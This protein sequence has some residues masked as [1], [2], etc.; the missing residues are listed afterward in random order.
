MFFL[1]QI[2]VFGLILIGLF[3]VT[4]VAGKYSLHYLFS[5]TLATLFFIIINTNNFGDRPF[6]F[7]ILFGLVC[8]ASIIKL[9]RK[10]G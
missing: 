8:L 1:T 9:M 7:V 4:K 2:V 10:N 6:L 3:F 5:L